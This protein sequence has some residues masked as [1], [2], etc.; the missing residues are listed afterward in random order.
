MKKK[1]ACVVVW[2]LKT[3]KRVK[4]QKNT[5]HISSYLF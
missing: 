5:K 2:A 3:L 1:S 4:Y